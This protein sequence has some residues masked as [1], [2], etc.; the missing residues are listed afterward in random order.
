MWAHISDYRELYIGLSWFLVFMLLFAIFVAA[1]FPGR[2]YDSCFYTIDRHG[3]QVASTLDQ[4]WCEAF[5]NGNIKEP[6]NTW[7]NLGF[8]LVGLVILWRIGRDRKTIAQR[9]NRFVSPNDM[10]YPAL[11]G[12]IVLFMGP[13][14][15]LYHASLKVWADIVDQTSMFLFVAF[16]CSYSA[17]QLWSALK[18]LSGYGLSTEGNV[19]E[20]VAAGVLFFAYAALQMV[21]TRGGGHHGSTVAIGLFVGLALLLQ[22]IF[23]VVRTFFSIKQ[24]PYEIWGALS[25]LVGAGAFILAVFFHANEAPKESNCLP[26][27]SLFNPQSSLQAHALWQIFSAVMTFFVYGFF[28]FER[29][30]N[31]QG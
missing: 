17:V 1:G 29:S 10:F 22:L 30:A 26:S 13:G 25:I 24:F 3:K 14:S 11:L 15:M 21:V 31:S 4:C 19:V 5:G 8:V 7:S 23:I 16:F 2:E 28:R 20:K 27:N 9:R 12:N 6:S 18:N